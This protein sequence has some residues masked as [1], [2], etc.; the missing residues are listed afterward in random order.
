MTSIVLNKIAQKNAKIFFILTIALSI[1]ILISAFTIEHLGFKPCPL[2]IY[3]RFPYGG[4]IILSIFAL[5]LK[6]YSKIMLFLIMLLQLGSIILAAYHSSIEFGWAPPLGLCNKQINY[7]T[8]SIQEIRNSISDSLPDCSIP[9]ILIF[10]LSMAAWNFILNIVLLLI[11]SLT[12]K[13][14]ICQNQISDQK[15]TT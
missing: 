6:K 4:L 13:N 10:G 1:L 2:C 14:F 11:S 12:L 9:A 15:K 7:A 5:F 8:L 3:A